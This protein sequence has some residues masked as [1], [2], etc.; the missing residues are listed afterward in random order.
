MCPCLKGLSV[1]GEISV[2]QTRFCGGS[3]CV[4]RFYW[5][6]Y[7][8]GTFPPISIHPDSL[9]YFLKIQNKTFVQ[10]RKK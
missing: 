9:V 3:V 7:G 4:W 2:G 8:P 5:Q 1:G 6:S 10:R